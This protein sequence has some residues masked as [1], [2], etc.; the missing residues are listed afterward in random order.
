MNGVDSELV[1]YW[2]FCASQMRGYCESS[3]QSKRRTPDGKMVETSVDPFGMSDDEFYPGRTDIW[4]PLFSRY[5]TDSYT[6][7]GIR[8][9]F[10]LVSD[11]S[12][13]ATYSHI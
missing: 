10:S 11:E 1:A 6:D 3:Q 8:T 2:R 12:W 9:Q 13:D 7:S 4:D 5:F